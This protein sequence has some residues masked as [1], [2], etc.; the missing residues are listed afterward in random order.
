MEFA[1]ECFEVLRPLCKH[2]AIS[3]DLDGSSDV[4]ADLSRALIIFDEGPKYG[5]NTQLLVTG[6]LMAGG[7]RHK[8]SLDPEVL[9]VVRCH[10]VSLSSAI[11]RDELFKMIPP[12]GGR[13]QTEPVSHRH[14]THDTLE[15]DRGDVMALIDDDEAIRLGDLPYV[16]PTSEALRHRD[17]DGALRLVA[18]AAKLT[19]LLGGNPKV[20]SETVSPLLDQGLPIDHYE[21]GEPVDAR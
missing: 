11:H 8:Y 21:C 1:R 12:V 13:G 18:A 14:L 6:L 2:E 19:D 20:L 16:L 9:I 10:P 7:V 17:I 3:L 15:G 5:L 4:T